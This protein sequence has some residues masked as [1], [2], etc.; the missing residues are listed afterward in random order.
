MQN[1]FLWDQEG[2]DVE[3]AFR[4]ILTKNGNEAFLRLELDRDVVTPLL[5]SPLGKAERRWMKRFK[6]RYLD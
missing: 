5:G 2:V 1:T 3:Q 4:E 6:L